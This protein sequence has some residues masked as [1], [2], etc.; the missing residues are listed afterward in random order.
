MHETEAAAAPDLARGPLRGVRVLEFA[1]LGPAPFAAMM[2]ADMGADVVRLE[3]P[4]AKRRARDIILRGR[5]S[6][7]LDLKQPDDAAC[8]RELALRADVLIEGFRPG[9]MERLGLGPQPLLEAN[10]ALVYA[11]MTGWGQTGPLALHGGHDINYIALA[12][13]LGAIGP[14]GQPPAVPLNLI[15][16]YG[17][18]SL[19]LVVGI[20]AAILESRRSG[21]G[22][23]VDC[24][25]CD[26]VLSMMSLFHAM[27]AS[28]T[29]HPERGANQLDGGSHFYSSYEC[30]DGRYI[31]V[32]AGEPQFYEAFRRVAGLSDPLF[33]RQR[34]PAAWPEL[35]SRVAAVFRTRTRAEWVAAFDGVDACVTPV[36]TLDESLAHPHFN[37]RQRVA[38]IDG[39]R[40]AAPAPAFS[41][42]RSAI[43]PGSVFP[44]REALASCWST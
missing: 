22:Q 24:A 18:G 25:I 31:A 37:D 21:A 30:K 32:G 15:G 26:N 44:S 43:R 6:F 14:A 11:R 42:T 28:G 20:L 19:F 8:A 23:V 9:V 38:E 29:W 34:D 27:A 4:G 41:R 17:G 5:R 7:A 33:D 12:G 40:Q 35:R 16:D 2:L 3:R 1:G 10:P 39:I 13:A 36:L